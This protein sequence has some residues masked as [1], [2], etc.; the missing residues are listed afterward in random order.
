MKDTY[1]ERRQSRKAGVLI[2]ILSL[3]LAALLSGIINWKWEVLAKERA[4]THLAEEVLRF[5]VLANSDSAEDQALKMQVKETVISYLEER[6]PEGL[7]VD[8]TKDWVKRHTR[9]LEQVS[10]EVIKG[11]GY[12]YPVSAA[13]TTCYFPRKSYGDLTFPEGNYT[14]LRIE[15]GAAKGQNWWCVLYP[16]LCFIDAVHAVVPEEGKQ[17]LKHVL[18]EEEYDML[19]E[20]TEIEVKWYLPELIE[21]I[22]GRIE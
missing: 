1:F 2:W 17:L 7:D 13:V 22:R 11:A 10:G 21:K 9:E 6:L 15:I 14:A 3:V 8:G 5:H 19:A 18:A 20:D 16:N 4:Q 12:D